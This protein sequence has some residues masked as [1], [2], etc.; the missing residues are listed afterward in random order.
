MAINSIDRILFIKKILQI[1]ICS[2]LIDLLH[3]SFSFLD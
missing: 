2:F 3:Y 1:L